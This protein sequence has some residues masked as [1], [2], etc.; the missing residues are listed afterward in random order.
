MQ[1]FK[2]QRG[3]RLS[4]GQIKMSIILYNYSCGSDDGFFSLIGSKSLRTT[5]KVNSVGAE[6]TYR[7]RGVA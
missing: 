1:S 4:G 3:K 7:L 2:I 5:L 6:L